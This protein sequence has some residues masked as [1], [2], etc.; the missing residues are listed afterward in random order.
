MAREKNMN[1][2]E[3]EAFF[4]LYS[5]KIGGGDIDFARRAYYG[6]IKTITEG[7]RRTERVELP[8]LGEMVVIRCPPHKKHHVRMRQFVLMPETKEIKFH[9]NRNFKEYVR[10]MRTIGDDLKEVSSREKLV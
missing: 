8:D 2:L 5:A 7:L 4:R 10:K 9:P 6:L 3:T 1:K